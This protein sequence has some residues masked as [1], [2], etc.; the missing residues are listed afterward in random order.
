MKKIILICATLL[1][2]SITYANNDALWGALIGGVIGNQIGSS[3]HNQYIGAAIGAVIA[4]SNDRDYRRYDNS[5]RN[6]NSHY[7]SGGYYTYVTQRV[8]VEPVYGFTDCGQRVMVRNGYWKTVR[9][10]VWVP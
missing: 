5:S 4:G 10:R 3:D 1:A 7:R 9:Q 6:Y 2:S 8:Y